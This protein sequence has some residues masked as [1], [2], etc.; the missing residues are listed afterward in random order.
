MKIDGKIYSERS[1]IDEWITIYPWS[2]RLES[3]VIKRNPEFDSFDQ[4]CVYLF[5]VGCSDIDEWDCVRL[6]GHASNILDAIQYFN[7]LSY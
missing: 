2:E 3:A 5:N 4:A 6:K 1:D 7:S